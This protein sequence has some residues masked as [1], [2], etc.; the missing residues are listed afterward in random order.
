MR[1]IRINDITKIIKNVPMLKG[2]KSAFTVGSQ[3]LKLLAKH[4][5]SGEATVAKKILEGTKNPV[6][7]VVYKS[8]ELLPSGKRAD[9]TIAGLT[10]RDGKKV[11]GQGAVSITKPGTNQSVVKYRLNLKDSRANGFI[12]GGKVADT[13]DMELA[14]MRKGGM[15]KADA[16]VADA[17]AHHLLINE[18]DAISYA[19][20]LN[21]NSFLEK[22]TNF[23]KKLQNGADRIMTEIRKVLR[24]ESFSKPYK[25]EK[26]VAKLEDLKIKKPNLAVNKFAN[27]EKV[28][29]P[30]YSAEEISELTKNVNPKILT[31]FSDL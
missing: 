29:T 3:Q 18:N 12:D 31:Y 26:C 22:Y 23:Q 25:V 4:G 17:T 24:G 7:K 6:L 28:K 20:D 30:N 21:C 19:K 2:S 8:E 15:I 1:I 14:L 9:Y 5:S 11:I 10:L 16:R 27:I 13:K